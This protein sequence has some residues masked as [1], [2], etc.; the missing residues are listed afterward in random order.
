MQSNEINSESELSSGLSPMVSVR[1]PKV[2]VI[3]DSRDAVELISLILHHHKCDVRVAHDGHEAVSSLVDEDFDLI[4]L[5]LSMPNMNGDEALMLV[6]HI[7][8]EKKK[9]AV[10]PVMIYSGVDTDDFELPTLN[11]FKVLGVFNK[12]NHYRKLMDTFSKVFAEGVP[13]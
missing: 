7:Y 11:N 1:R 13:S 12:R 2:L 5:D 3:D 4:V 9:Y 6:D 8:G 10:T